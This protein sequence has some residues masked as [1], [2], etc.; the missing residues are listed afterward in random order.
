MKSETTH[1]NSPLKSSLP[2]VAQTG[3]AQ[4]SAHKTNLSFAEYMKNVVS[5]LSAKLTTANYTGGKNLAL[6]KKTLSEL[7]AK[8]D[9]AIND[10]NAHKVDLLLKKFKFLTVNWHLTHAIEKGET[11]IVN[12]LA[13][14]P[15][16]SLNVLDA[17]LGKAKRSGNSKVIKI[18]SERI[19][20]KTNK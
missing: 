8:V 10:G 17:A 18:L 11:E 5:G 12:M 16:A 14:H 3:V 9:A 13:N 7:R 15:S 4:N 1:S 6:D 19:S 20:A 2:G